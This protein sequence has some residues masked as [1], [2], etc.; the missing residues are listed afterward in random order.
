M[1]VGCVKVEWKPWCV[2]LPTYHIKTTDS[3]LI[4][5]LLA[6]HDIFTARQ[7]PD[8]MIV[9]TPELTVYSSGHMHADTVA[10][11][12]VKTVEHSIASKEFLYLKLVNSLFGLCMLHF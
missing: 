10:D 3:A 6:M 1:L 9:C 5:P 7:V 11:I 8:S 4:D 12:P 2:V